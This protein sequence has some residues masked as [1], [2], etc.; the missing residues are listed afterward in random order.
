MS[1]CHNEDND[2]VSTDDDDDNDDDNND[3]N[4]DDITSESD[5][6]EAAGPPNS[7]VA[8]APL[9]LLLHASGL[10][11]HGFYCYSYRVHLRNGFSLTHGAH[12]PST[13]GL[14]GIISQILQ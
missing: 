4:N 9:V 1:D 3:D 12:M 13:A 11:L 6:E 5:E 7:G 14:R 10:T 2:D 8:F